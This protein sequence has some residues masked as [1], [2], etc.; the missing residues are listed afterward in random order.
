MKL[1]KTLENNWLSPDEITTEDRINYFKKNNPNEKVIVGPSESM[2]KSK[3]I[4][5]IQKKL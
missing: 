3:K 2:S 1:T 5:S 4:L